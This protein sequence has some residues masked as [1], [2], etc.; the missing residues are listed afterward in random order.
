MATE[1]KTEQYNL[2][3][4]AVEETTKKMDTQIEEQQSKNKVE[5]VS[6]SKLPD[7]IEEKFFKKHPEIATLNSKMKDSNG[8][9]PLYDLTSSEHEKWVSELTE[10]ILKSDMVNLTDLKT[11][12]KS[13]DDLTEFE[14]HCFNNMNKGISDY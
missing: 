1:E 9:H 4:A 13:I 12:Q 3:K 7:E 6:G 8:R 10:L 14:Y 5:I 2:L 11:I